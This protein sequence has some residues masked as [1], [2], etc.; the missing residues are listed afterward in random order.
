LRYDDVMYILKV[1]KDSGF[2]KVSLVTNGWK[3]SL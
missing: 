2:T 3:K 1:I